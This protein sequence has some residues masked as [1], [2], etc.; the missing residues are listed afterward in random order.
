M[1]LYR[2]LEASESAN[3]TLLQH[4]ADLNRTLQA[5]AVE[6]AEIRRQLKQ[7]ASYSVAV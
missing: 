5:K 6:E 4:V 7:E 1:T 3:A 2:Q